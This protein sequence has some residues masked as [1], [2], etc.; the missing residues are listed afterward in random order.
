MG[1]FVF[2]SIW[3]AFSA[4]YPQ[5]FDEDFHFGLIKTYSHY[6]LP[7]LTKQPPDANAFGAVARDPSY[8]YHYLMSFPYRFIALFI[9]SQTGQ[10]ITLRVFDIII[11]GVGLYL[12]RKVLLRVGLSKGLTNLCLLIFILIPIVPQLAAQISYDNLFF[13]LVAFICLQTF[14]ITDRIK[15]RK[16]PS[17]RIII[18]IITMLLTAIVKYA[19]MPISLAVVL[20]LVWLIYGTYKKDYKKLL[21]DFKTNFNKHSKKLRWLLV[22]GL[23][24]SA[25]MFLERDGVNLIR[26]H[27]IEPNC[28]KVLSV[29]QC[30]PYSAWF[31][32]Y[33]RHE[34][35]VGGKANFQY[36]FIQY[37]GQWFYWMWYRLFFAVN[38]AASNF[39]N[40]GP[41]PVPS[42]C[43]IFLAV[44]G[45]I[46]LIR[47][48]KKIFKDNPYLVL[49]SM[50]VVIYSLILFIQGYIT[51][52]YT[53]VLENMNGRY[54]IPI[55][56]PLAAI[57]G[58][59]LSR[60]LRRSRVTKALVSLIVLVLFMQGGGLLNFILQSD[61]SWYWDNKAVVKVN[62][63]VRK[64]FK[65]VVIK[66]G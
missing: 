6:W 12:F 17:V 10:V 15:K 21:S 31:V 28:S 8:L 18:L 47:S 49:L 44:I 62:N 35:L 22:I 3:I 66:H 65:K 9:H 33:Q 45:L 2:Q 37:I 64:V 39:A 54:L 1:L 26:F 24:I 48:R 42:I 4:I 40:K 53:A 52:K 63:D 55:L 16:L 59:A 32:D 5:A 34:D 14:D 25:G 20:Y 50:I 30:Q 23:V 43:A 36:N 41:L 56:L 27:N 61:D 38:G 57:I 29:N 46:A 7:F 19:S 58:L 51:Y 11:F 60:S 13:T